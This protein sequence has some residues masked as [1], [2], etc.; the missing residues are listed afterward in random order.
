MQLETA[1]TQAIVTVFAK[2]DNCTKHMGTRQNSCETTNSL[3]CRLLCYW[4]I[5][6]IP[7]FRPS[8]KL[9]LLSCILNKDWIVSLPRWLWSC[10]KY[11]CMWIRWHFWHCSQT[12]VNDMIQA[13]TSIWQMEH[14]FSLLLCEKMAINAQPNVTSPTFHTYFSLCASGLFSSYVLGVHYTQSQLPPYVTVEFANISAFTRLLWTMILCELH[15]ALE[16]QE[17]EEE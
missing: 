6:C 7:I 14:L 5:L 12:R 15:C 1:V 11:E 8:L 16:G 4:N 9:V 2:R 10:M 3:N 13:Y 17:S